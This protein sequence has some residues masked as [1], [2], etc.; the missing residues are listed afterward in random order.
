MNTSTVVTSSPAMGRVP[1][2]VIRVLGD[3]DASSCA[4]LEALADQVYQEGARYLLLDLSQATYISSSGLRTLHHIYN[5][6]RP[7]EQSDD[8][9]VRKG[10]AD[11]T[12]NSAHLKLLRPTPQAM[13]T[14]RLSGFDMY[15]E[16]FQ[17]ERQ[18]IASF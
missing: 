14:L 1:V 18:A 8:A 3:L 5:L 4:R 12:Y 6:L 9:A 11:G 17:D 10:L 7:E 13:E 16:V 2:T 15:L